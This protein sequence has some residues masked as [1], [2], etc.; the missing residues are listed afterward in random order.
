AGAST[1][2]DSQRFQRRLGARILALLGAAAIAAPGAGC[3]GDV[4]HGTTSTT[5]GTS[6]GSGGA[7][8]TGHGASATTSSG[9]T[10]VGGGAGSGGLTGSGG[11]GGG[12]G[13][14]GSTDTDNPPSQVCLPWPV[15]P[16]AG[17][18]DPGP[19]PVDATQVLALFES[20]GCPRGWE[21]SQVVS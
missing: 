9:S 19:C 7:S 20:L 3:K 12:G 8:T 4:S 13:G 15:D 5:N 18:G 17:P 2:L 10:G 1:M 21:P 6:P 11:S 14:G 16:D